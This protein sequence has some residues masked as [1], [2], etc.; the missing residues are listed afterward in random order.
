MVQEVTVSKAAAVRQGSLEVSWE[1]FLFALLLARDVRI[2]ALVEGME[3]ARYRR[4]LPNMRNAF[5][6]GQIR[7]DWN[8][9]ITPSLRILLNWYRLGQATDPRD[10]VY[11]L[12]GITDAY[13]SSNPAMFSYEESVGDVYRLWTIHILRLEG[14]LEILSAANR[15]PSSE[16]PVRCSW[17][18]D[19]STPGTS[20]AP[21]VLTSPTTDLQATKGSKIEPQFREEDTILGL[22]GYTIDSVVAVGSIYD[23]TVDTDPILGSNS[24]GKFFLKSEIWRSWEGVANIQRRDKYRPTNEDIY[25]A[26]W[27]TIA[28]G[29]ASVNAQEKELAKRDFYPLFAMRRPW[30]RIEKFKIHSV[31]PLYWICSMFLNAWTNSKEEF[32]A[33]SMITFMM[34]CIQVAYRR[35]IRTKKGYIGLATHG[36]KVGDQIALFKG[37]RFPFVIRPADGQHWSLV[38]DSYIHGIMHGELWDEQKCE[39]FWIR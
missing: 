33:K 13:A 9:G 35:M 3:E 10:K 37:G 22:A 5:S 39:A 30:R 21:H 14:S 12:A 7:D 18:P 36:A 23:T 6:L 38:G 11:A 32:D 34:R 15:Y 25:D 26:Y 31:K 2:S 17:V 27:Q 19:W 29:E 4:V 28:Y 16:S 1:R 24:A 20:K 8:S